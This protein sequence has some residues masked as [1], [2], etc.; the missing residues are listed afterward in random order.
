LHQ[1]RNRHSSTIHCFTPSRHQPPR[2]VDQIPL[3]TH[4]F[5]TPHTRHLM[6]ACHGG[7]NSTRVSMRELSTDGRSVEAVVGSFFDTAAHDWRDSS[8]GPAT[9]SWYTEWSFV[10]RTALRSDAPNSVVV[11][12]DVDKA[13]RA[14]WAA[15]RAEI[16]E[17]AQLPVLVLLT[18]SVATAHVNF[19]ARELALGYRR[20]DWCVWPLE[21][22]PRVATGYRLWRPA[23]DWLAAV[24]TKAPHW[25]HALVV[26][27]P[28]LASS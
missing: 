28:I 15:V 23:F 22:A 16:D 17:H 1:S 24:V 18:G 5:R 27:P 10:H 20:V 25:K 14:R 19:A 8:D 9:R 6:G 11:A 12:I 26:Q 2:F 3:P 21:A 13:D 4:S 7:E